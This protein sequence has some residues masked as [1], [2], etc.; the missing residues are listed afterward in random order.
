[1]GQI[2]LNMPKYPQKTGKMPEIEKNAGKK[3]KNN[4]NFWFINIIVL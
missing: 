3:E 4:Q 2:G 1:M